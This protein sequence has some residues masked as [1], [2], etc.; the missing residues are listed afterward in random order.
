MERQE[1]LSPQID[2][3]GL[4]RHVARDQV[5]VELSEGEVPVAKLVP[6]ERSKTMADLDRALRQI[7]PLGDDAKSY[8]EDIESFRSSLQSL[9][10][11]WE[12]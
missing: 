10:D 5:T 1:I 11:K 6:I 9:D 3:P 7:P 8:E 12:S 4:V 2:W